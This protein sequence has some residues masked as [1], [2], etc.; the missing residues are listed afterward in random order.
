MSDSNF[1]QWF[2]GKELSTDWTSRYFP[3]WAALLEAR[4]EERLDVLE[5]GSWEGRSAIFFLNFLRNC[6]LS[7]I[8]SF[9]GSPEHI[10]V[11]RWADALPHIERRFDANV[12][13]FGA[14]VT[15]IKADAT[16]ALAG[17]IVQGQRFDLVYV[18]GGHTS[19][20]VL[21][22]TVMVWT[23]VR[24]RGIVIF[25]D[26]EWSVLPEELDRPK[27]AIDSFLAVHA[28]QYRLLHKGY[29]VIIEKQVVPVR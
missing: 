1:H 17:L 12:A 16:L 6:R 29:Q 2:E 25:D 26:Y 9:K 21:S 19:A 20:E 15:K 23:M 24:N 11:A 14:R 27:L 3:Q 28:G 22:D 18:D 8:D 4:K 5:V 10:R 7:C 13:E